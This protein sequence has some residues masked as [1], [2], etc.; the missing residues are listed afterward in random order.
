MRGGRPGLALVRARQ[1]LR[2]G[3]EWV[4]SLRRLRL[5]AP[6]CG[7]HGGQARNDTN[8]KCLAWPITVAPLRWGAQG[9]TIGLSW[10]SSARNGV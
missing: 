6:A 5:P 9:A 4:C 8:G 2:Y 10:N 7:R 1:S 3:V